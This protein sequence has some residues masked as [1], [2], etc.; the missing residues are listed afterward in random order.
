MYCGQT[1]RMSVSTERKI[2]DLEIGDKM[3]GIMDRV[4]S[5]GAAGEEKKKKDLPCLRLK[6]ITKVEKN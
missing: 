6:N 5:R 4:G 1:V 2:W 3:R